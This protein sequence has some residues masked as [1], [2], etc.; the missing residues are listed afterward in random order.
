[1]IQPHEE[2]LTMIVFDLETTGVD[3]ATDR[4]VQIGYVVT[5]AKG[6]IIEEYQ[7]LVNPE[8]PIPEKA[9]EVH[10]I[11]D[12]MVKDSPK[13]CELADRLMHKVTGRIVAGYNIIRFDIPVLIAEF[14]RCGKTWNPTD[15]LDLL[16]ALR[17]I[18]PM[19]LGSVYKRQTGKELEGAHDALIDVKATSELIKIFG[20]KHDLMAHGG[21]PEDLLDWGGKFRKSKEEKKTYFRFGKHRDEV[22]G[23]E[24]LDFLQWMSDKDF[25]P[26]TL[27]WVR[28]MINTFKKRLA[29]EARS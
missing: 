27:A 19:D 24:H 8:I 29:K 15:V 13:F 3:V 14:G 11:T 26:S 21:L 6:D 10:G 5:D 17:N 1:M 20:E 9:S 25:H 4:I 23:P 16:A 22:V 2:K 12:E 7:T 28:I 18:W